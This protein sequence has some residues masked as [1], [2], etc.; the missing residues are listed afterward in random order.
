MNFSQEFRRAIIQGEPLARFISLLERFDNCNSILRGEEPDSPINLA[1]VNDRLDVVKLLVQR[2]A[3][4]TPLEIYPKPENPYPEFQNFGL[5]DDEDRFTGSP[6]LTAAA[7]GKQEIFNFLAPLASPEQRREAT[8]YLAEA[9]KHNSISDS[10]NNTTFQ[11]VVGDHP[12]K[13]DPE[14]FG[15]WLNDLIEST[16]VE[17][18]PSD[19]LKSAS[20][21]FIERCQDRIRQ[22]LDIDNIGDN[23]CA[24]LW[25]A[26]HNGY[27]EAV[28]T[29]IE[30]GGSVDIPNQTD[31]WTPLLIA[32]DAHIPWTFGTK[33]FWGKAASRQVE[34]VNILLQAGANVNLQGNNGE[35][36]LILASE[37]DPDKWELGETF[38]MARR[39]MISV[40]RNVG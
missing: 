3:S 19:V 34:I 4:L 20:L 29:L 30:L 32:V 17:L 25:T 40:L 6:L 14:E 38:D 1:V 33:T 10:Q 26:A 18:D 35:T 21:Q 13:N 9:I 27:V 15:K 22:G 36:A 24:F 12:T 11:K 16:I 5:E 2:G 23:G 8:L 39:E 31:G 37:F 28:R 7:Q